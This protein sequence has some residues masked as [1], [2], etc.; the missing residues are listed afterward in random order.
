MTCTTIQNRLGIQPIE[1]TAG[2]Q[3]FLFGAALA[4]N[5]GMSRQFMQGNVAACEE[6]DVLYAV[7]VLDQLRPYFAPKLNFVDVQQHFY[8]GK[9]AFLVNGVWDNLTDGMTTNQQK[10]GYTAFPSNT[11]E[12]VVFQSS[13]AGYV[14]SNMLTPQQEEACIRFLKYMLSEEVQQRLVCET[15]QAPENP[16]LSEE[17]IKQEVPVLGN[18][19]EVCNRAEIPISSFYLLLDSKQDQELT[20]ALDKMA[21]G[22]DVSQELIDILTD[23]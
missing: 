8:D 12:K 18:A 7:T 3:R 17:W 20:N 14:V 13:S 4:A 1:I 2:P 10:I 22:T 15:R 19:I 21:K 5:E 11:G 9:T 23:N 6:E 16:N